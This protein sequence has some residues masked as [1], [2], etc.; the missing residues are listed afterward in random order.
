MGSMFLGNHATVTSCSFYDFKYYSGIRVSGSS[1]LLMDCNSFVKFSYYILDVSYVKA[2]AHLEFTNNT[3]DSGGILVNIA[4]SAPLTA[5]TFEY[6]NLLH[7][8]NNS[9]NCGAGGNPGSYNV[10]DMENNYW[11]TSDSNMINDGIEDYRDNILVP[12]YINHSNALSSENTDC[13]GGNIGA[14]P[15]F[16]MM[17]LNLYPNPADNLIRLDGV[18]GQS[19]V[20]IYNM[21]GVEVF[22]GNFEGSI[23]IN[24]S[25]FTS[26][27]YIIHL[28]SSEEGMARQTFVVKH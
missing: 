12:V 13:S 7:Y 22:N 15:A 28:L 8:S 27:V 1:Y 3:L 20:I 23:E 26:G 2:N 4:G 11:G 24:T 25:D 6:N 10:L 9:V 17:G 14:V 18:R 21:Q 19:N 5:F 16:N